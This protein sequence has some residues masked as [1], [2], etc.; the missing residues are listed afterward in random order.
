MGVV[1][2]SGADNE[3]SERSRAGKATKLARRGKKKEKSGE[4]YRPSQWWP[5]RTGGSVAPTWPALCA[6]SHA[7][8]GWHSYNGYTC[9]LYCPRY[10][11]LST[12]KDAYPPS[13]LPPAKRDPT[14][15]AGDAH[16]SAAAADGGGGLVGVRPISGHRN[17][18]PYFP[19]AEAAAGALIRGA[20]RD[21]GPPSPL[22][23]HAMGPPGISDPRRQAEG[24][25]PR[26]ARAEPFPERD[27]L[28]VS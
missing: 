24:R 5:T 4:G 28:R 16:A 1:N 13:L 17:D 20:L 3:G 26:Y 10:Y 21:V 27:L 15:S 23:K 11:Y 14:T 9:A 19:R 18:G 2:A 6:L 25:L 8:G 7:G 22:D 12:R